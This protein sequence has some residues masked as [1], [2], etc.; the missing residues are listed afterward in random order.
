MV[1]ATDTEGQIREAY[2][3]LSDGPRVPVSLAA[4]RR[5]MWDVPETAVDAALVRLSGR[6]GVVLDPKATLALDGPVW[7]AAPPAGS[8]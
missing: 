4:I 3:E 6:P 5:A 7:A 8:S 1:I 2:W